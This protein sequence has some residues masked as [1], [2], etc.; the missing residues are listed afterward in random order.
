MTDAGQQIVAG[1]AIRPAR[2]DEVPA[3][4]QMIAAS[5]RTLSAG[6]YDP[7]EIEA[8]I[9]HG[10]GAGSDLFAAGP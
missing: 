9:T 6:F 10:F 7:R 5:A 8:A 3:L 1:V 4:E 2:A